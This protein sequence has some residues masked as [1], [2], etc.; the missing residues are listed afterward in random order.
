M[1]FAIFVAATGLVIFVL[2]F[3]AT[4]PDT[5]QIQRSRLIEAPSEKVF[6]LLEDFHNWP[7]WAPQDTGDPTVRRS[8]SGA[9][10]GTGAISEWMSEGTGG[11]GSMSITEAVPPKTLAITVDFVRPFPAH[12]INRFLLEPSGASTNVTWTMEGTNLYLMKVMSL[13]VNPDKTMGKHFET[14]LNNLKTVAEK[15]S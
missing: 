8:F 10:R 2:I 4:R 7:L 9:E 15:N 5:F 6:A 1:A 3:A 12:N 11:A 13:V 14:G